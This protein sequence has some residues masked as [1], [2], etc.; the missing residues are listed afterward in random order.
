MMKRKIF[1]DALSGKAVYMDD[2]GE[3][4]PEVRDSSCA[5]ALKDSR[6]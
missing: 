5:S 4:C 3:M 2:E 1:Y 6:V